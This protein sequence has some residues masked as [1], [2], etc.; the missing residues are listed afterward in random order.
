MFK[1]EKEWIVNF[2]DKKIGW[3][4]IDKKM[5]SVC[6]AKIYIKK[7]GKR[8]SFSAS[9]LQKVFFKVFERMFFIF[10]NLEEIFT[11]IIVKWAEVNFYNDNSK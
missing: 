3:G 8:L 4:E 10:S 5:L 11:K 1:N 2:I 7:R 6:F 9:S